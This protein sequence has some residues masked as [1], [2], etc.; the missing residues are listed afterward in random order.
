MNLVDRILRE[1]NIRAS[2]KRVAAN[3]GAPGVDGMTVEELQGYFDKHGADIKIQI[4]EKRYTPQPV[5]RVYIPKPN[6]DKLRPLGIPTSVDRV[7]QEAVS[8]VLMEEYEPYF[9]DHS[10]GYR[11]NRDCHQAIREA[12]NNLNEG[13][14]WVI[15]F[16][17]EKYF[18]TVNHDTLI[19]ILRERVN[20]SVVLHLI[21]SFLKAGVMEGGLV[22]PT[23][24][25][26][27]QGGPLSCVLSNIY[28]DKLDKEL[29]SRGL[30]HVR[31]ADD[32]AVYVRSEKS[33]DRVMRSVSS[34]LERKL[35]LKVNVTKT[36]V[37]RPGK[38]EYLG[39]GFWNDKGTWK[40][41]PLASRKK[42]LRDKIREVTCRRRAAA[43]PLSMTVTK[44]NQILRGWIN[45]YGIGS[46]KG[47]MQETGAWVRHRI[48][49]II[50]KQWKKPKTIAKGLKWYCQIFGFTFSD[51]EIYKV[52]NSRK[53]LY[54]QCNGDVINYILSPKVLGTKL[55]RKGKET[56]YPGL[57]DPLAYY[58]NRI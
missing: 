33:A 9:S 8:R 52:A 20:D 16:D 3:K 7:V 34:W 51:E 48:R 56:V 32:V 21:R 26:V 27:P 14:T 10:Y 2:I 39:F 18:D 45:Y 38:S 53:G 15:D 40:C 23:E 17:I 35:F 13:Y 41:M 11:P 42:R 57:I 1:E 43:I 49:V 50:V 31:Y 55:K 29:E 47:F 54:A 4:R 5:R 12:L 22:S 25:G 46:M 19:S 36:K 28:L 58:L 6:S 44:V 30:R 37:V 24:Q